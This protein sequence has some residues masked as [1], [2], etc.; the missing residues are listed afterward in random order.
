[1]EALSFSTTNARSKRPRHSSLSLSLRKYIS[2]LEQAINWSLSISP[3]SI[4]LVK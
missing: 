4:E 1:M 3:S 2:I